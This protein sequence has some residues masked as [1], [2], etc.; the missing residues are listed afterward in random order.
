MKRSMRSSLT[1]LTQTAQKI[2]FLNKQKHN[3]PSAQTARIV[4]TTLLT[5]R[6]CQE[7]R[8]TL[9]SVLSKRDT[10]LFI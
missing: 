4:L 2:G 6:R 9:L 5:L 3:P 1:A 8:A 10:C 7:K